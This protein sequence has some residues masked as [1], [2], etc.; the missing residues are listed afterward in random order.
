ML[1]PV[2]FQ[3]YV[4]QVLSDLDDV[5]SAAY[6][7]DFVIAYHNNSWYMV[8]HTLQAALDKIATAILVIRVELDARKTKR[9]GYGSRIHLAKLKN[10]F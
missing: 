5:H 3:I 8:K 10:C 7:D 6:A 2:L 9:C 1:G 4:S